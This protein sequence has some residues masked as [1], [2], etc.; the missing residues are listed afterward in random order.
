MGHPLLVLS[1]SVHGEG[2]SIVFYS[3]LTEK[4]AEY[5][6]FDRIEKS[7]SGFKPIALKEVK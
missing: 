2:V 3:F 1:H 6:N 4:C 5:P 7:R